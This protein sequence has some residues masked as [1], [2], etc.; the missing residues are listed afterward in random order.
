MNCLHEGAPS[1]LRRPDHTKA[2]KLCIGGK[3]L[4]DACNCALRKHDLA[5]R[6]CFTN[7]SLSNGC[8]LNISNYKGSTEGGLSKYSAARVPLT[9]SLPLRAPFRALMFCVSAAALLA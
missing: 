2:A 6:L 3:C 5:M 1:A 9:A 4:V 8:C 7:T